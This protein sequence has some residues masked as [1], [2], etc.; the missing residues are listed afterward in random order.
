MRDGLRLG[1]HTARRTGLLP[2]RRPS[3]EWLRSAA[4][5][6]RAR[7][8]KRR[9]PRQLRRM[10][11]L[12]RPSGFREKWRRGSGDVVGF[13]RQL[14]L[15]LVHLELLWHRHGVRAVEARAAE[16][17]RGAA[18]Y[19]PHEPRD[20][21]VL[22]AVGSDALTNL[23]HGA[24]GRDQLLGR[25]DVDSHEAWEAHWRARDPHVDLTRARRPEALDDPP[26]GGAAD[27]RVIDRDD[28]LASDRSR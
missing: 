23:V 16:L 24:S 8:R 21:E 15:H 19:C 2:Q 22:Q 6:A 18:A 11:A 27:D 3:R 14:E 17:L 13:E 1:A 12:P 4:L 26:R 9:C 20:R 25:T 10:T 7:A 28:P 5:P